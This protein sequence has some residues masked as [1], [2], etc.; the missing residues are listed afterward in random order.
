MSSEEEQ[1]RWQMCLDAMQLSPQQQEHLLLS[2]RSHLQHMRAIYQE[3]HNLNMK[4]G[5]R[6]AQ[7]CAARLKPA[8]QGAS[9]SLVGGRPVGRLLGRDACPLSGAAS[10]LHCGTPAGLLAIC[11]WPSNAPT[12]PQEMNTPFPH[13][14]HSHNPPPPPARPPRPW[15]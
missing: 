4:V 12:A 14:T 6:A 10:L 13:P 3:R 8:G 15:R 7:R 1:R 9:V 2:R 5:R 11:A